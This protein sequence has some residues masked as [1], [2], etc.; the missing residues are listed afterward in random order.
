MCLVVDIQRPDFE[1]RIAI[2]KR[3]ANNLD[4]FLSDEIIAKIAHS[5]RSSIRELEGSLIKLSAFADVMKVEIDEEMVKDLL[6]LNSVNSEGV[7][8]IEKVGKVISQHYGIPL[9]DIKS[10]SRN[11]D[12]THARHLAMYLTQKMISATLIEIGQFYGGRDHASVIHAIDKVREKMDKVPS[13]S[14]EILQLEN[15]IQN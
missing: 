12:I 8:S 14:K 11:K 9:A 10:R 5:V 6:S 3:K 13:L 7:I 2:L 15:K 1:T 4:L